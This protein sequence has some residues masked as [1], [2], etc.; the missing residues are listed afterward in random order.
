M[1]TSFSALV[2]PNRNRSSNSIIDQK[3]DGKSLTEGPTVGELGPIS[4]AFFP[5]LM[6]SPSSFGGGY[7]V[8]RTPVHGTGC[9]SCLQGGQECW[10]APRWKDSSLLDQELPMSNGRTRSN[11][12]FSVLGPEQPAAASRLEESAAWSIPAGSPGWSPVD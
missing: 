7:G 12:E 5:F 1:L 4:E 3:F 8:L 10:L 6:V 11:V 2:T 9:Y